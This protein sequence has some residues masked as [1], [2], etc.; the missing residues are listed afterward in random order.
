MKKR[1]V[2]R[3]Y[4]EMNCESGTLSNCVGETVNCHSLW[5]VIP[6]QGP[7]HRN[8]SFCV[9]ACSNTRAEHALRKTTA[10]EETLKQYEQENK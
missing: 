8:K 6:P 7:T 3:L 5:N 2:E 10:A 4:P 9:L 1:R